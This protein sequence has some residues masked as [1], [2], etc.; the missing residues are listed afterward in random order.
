T[1]Y[2]RSDGTLEMLPARA[3]MHYLKSWFVIDFSVVCLDWLDLV[4][5]QS[6]DAARLGKSV[7]M[8][9]FVKVA[10][11][12]RLMR[13]SRMSEMLG[14]FAVIFRTGT[15][16]T[17]LGILKIMAG[18][19]I[20]GHVLACVWFR[21]GADSDSDENWLVHFKY[22]DTDMVHVYFISLHWAVTQFC[23][24]MEVYPIS[25][26]ERVLNVI[27]LYA[28]FFLSA[29]VISS[30]TSSMTKLDLLTV[31][32]DA[33]LT[34]LKQFM[35]DNKISPRLTVRIQRSILLALED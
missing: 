27:A 2:S 9:R 28:S 7:K 23:G 31:Q 12:I 21:V 3:A 4:D 25:F 17:M 34:A 30:L 32:R 8:L 22:K 6:L 10:R 29:A 13:F 5:L 14:R 1:G 35:Y 20:Y 18:M 11:L 24:A 16:P 19:I 33:K 26:D 15:F